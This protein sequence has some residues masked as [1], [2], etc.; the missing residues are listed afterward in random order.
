M[1]PAKPGSDLISANMRMRV[2][3]LHIETRLEVSPRPIKPQQALPALMHLVNAVVQETE[4]EIA[5]KGLKISCTKGCGA[6]CRQLV[7]IS[8]VEAHHLRALVD[9]MPPERRRTI[10]ARFAEA[11]RRLE[12][13]GLKDYLMAPTGHTRDEAAAFGL[14]YY[15][16]DL[17]CPFL[18]DESCSIHPDR[19]LVCREYLVTSPAVHCSRLDDEEL[20][21]VEVPKMSA[22]A[23]TLTD[24][25]AR[26]STRW[27]ALSLTLEW[28][29]KNPDRFALRTG[30]EW[31][32]AFLKTVSA[33]PRA[34]PEPPRPAKTVNLKIPGGEVT[35]Q[36]ALPAIHQLSEHMIGES[37][38]AVERS[39][40]TISCREGCAACCRQAVPVADVE[41]WA[42]AD[43]IEAMPEPRRAVIRARF[44]E[45]ERRLDAADLAIVDVNG[46]S[47]D[48]LKKLA[49]TYFDL[50][51]DCPFLD[52][53]RCS[54]HASRPLACREH[55]VTS[56]PQHCWTI[57]RGLV[58][59]VRSPPL[60]WA[61][62]HLTSEGTPPQSRAALLP[63]L[64]RWLASNPKSTATKPAQQWVERLMKIESTLTKGPGGS[65]P[66]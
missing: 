29:A 5:R 47:P 17:A 63:L 36:Q 30:P 15:A 45:A 46:L 25:T 52:S 55:V 1:P 41:A 43:L 26:Q 56:L 49:R 21:S 32:D 59:G 8:D 6:C 42:L 9:A 7:P 39:G 23:R 60:G 28:V 37:V 40:K 31:V 2:G 50:K 35:A 53:E 34:E 24:P 62:M 27:V 16:L 14:K 13:A 19:P 58:E 44:A 33:P 64:F 3:P 11:S 20:E 38:A 51:L 22:L 54:I 10:E 48:E 12:E 61:L 65:P 18:E 4:K 57:D 66:S